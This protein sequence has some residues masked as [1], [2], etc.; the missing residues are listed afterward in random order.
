MKPEDV[1]IIGAGPAGAS[2]AIQL[3]RYG[4]DPLLLE[5][6]RVGGLLVN[7]NLVENYPGFPQGIP[8]KELVALLERHIE[9]AGVKPILE[10][11][12]SLDH[13]GNYFI[14]DTENRTIFSIIAAIASGTRPGTPDLQIPELVTNRVFCEIYPILESEGKKIA[15]VGAGDAA[16]D[17]ALNLAKRNKVFLLNRSTI[18]RCLPLLYERAIEHLGITYMQG[19]RVSHIHPSE[20]GMILECITSR[21]SRE[22]SVDYLV[23]AIGREPNMGFLSEGLGDRL[24]GLKEKGLLYL[25]GDVKNGSYRQVAIAVGDGIKAAMK[26]QKRLLERRE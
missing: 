2:L 24:T 12:V 6:K 25:I 1:V 10:K 5:K 18:L 7:A 17:Y 22:L 21:G 9:V 26:I 19:I 4:I 23:F 15:I 16:F 11:V 3:R 14:L 8:G 13:D 20:D